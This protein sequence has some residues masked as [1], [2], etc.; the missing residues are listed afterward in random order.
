[1]IEARDI[2]HRYRGQS[3][4][5]LAGVTL[6][7]REGSLF[8]LLGP[9]GSGKTTLI[10][11]LTGVLR[12][13][14]GAVRISGLDMPA[15][16]RE[17]QHILS[18]VPQENAFYPTLTVAE[19]LKF[20]ASVQ[21]IQTNVQAS[22][23]DEALHITGLESAT[24]IRANRLSGGMKRRL[25]I[26]LGLLNHPRLLFLDE[27]TVGI[28]PQSRQFLLEAIKRINAS[29]TTVVYCSHYMEEVEYLC[30]DVA[31]LDFGRVLKQGSLAAL[32]DESRLVA[33]EVPVRPAGLQ[34]LFFKLTKRDL[35]DTM[36]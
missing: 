24:G 16:A 11:I 29:G 1:M 20:F 23:I 22:R 27:P 36:P 17:V 31:I 2:V 15:K 13:D 4:P 30:D 19:N 26:A 28:D 5:A 18:L 35:R 8:G 9:N 3:V 32:L 33:A 12:G 21:D 6:D 14:S 34:E 7:V 10:S 25:S